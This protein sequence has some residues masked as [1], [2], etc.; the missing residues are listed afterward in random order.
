MTSS[1]PRICAFVAV[2]LQ[3]GGGGGTLGKTVNVTECET[4]VPSG[5]FFFPFLLSENCCWLL[6][7]ENTD[8]HWP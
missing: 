6:D 1:S 3:G 5:W 2:V 7:R 8:F 4:H